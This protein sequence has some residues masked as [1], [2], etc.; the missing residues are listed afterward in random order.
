MQGHHSC[1]CRTEIDAVHVPN[2]ALQPIGAGEHACQ[3]R[4]AA[5][6]LVASDER[7][8]TDAAI[9]LHAQQLVRNLMRGT[10]R[11][12][13]APAAAGTGSG[14]HLEALLA[15]RNIDRSDVHQGLAARARM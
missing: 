8:H 12:S 6:A 5:V 13:N 2:L 3:R 14:M 1:S 11:V 9:V 4:D 15:R 10:R 7:L